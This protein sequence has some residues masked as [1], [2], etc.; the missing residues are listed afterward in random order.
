MGNQKG[1]TLIEL[2]VVI[3]ILGI[4]A[5]V[6]VPKFVDMQVDARI[7]AVDGMS[8]AVQSASALAHAQSLVN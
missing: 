7:S 8:G 4:L 2:V 3:V 1:F 5:A 6:A